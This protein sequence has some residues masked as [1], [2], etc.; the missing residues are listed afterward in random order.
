[1]IDVIVVGAGPSGLMLAGEPR[2]HGVQVLVLERDAE[3]TRQVRALGLHV[4]S[5]EV[6]DQR[7][8]LGRFLAHGRTYPRS[9]VCSPASESRRRSGWTPRIPTSSASRRPS[10]S[11]C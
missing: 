2:L 1:M 4:R 6:M 8:L 9:V 10:P 3:P 11:A 5:I 7:G